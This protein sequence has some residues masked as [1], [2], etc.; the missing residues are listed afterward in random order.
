MD[1]RDHLNPRYKG[2]GGAGSFQ[3]TYTAGEWGVTISF[4][5]LAPKPV[6]YQIVLTDRSTGFYWQGEVNPA[7]QVKEEVAPKA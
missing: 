3:H 7:G 4:Q 2:P 5:L 6:S 1:N